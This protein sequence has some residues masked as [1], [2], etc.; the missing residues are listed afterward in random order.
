MQPPA[1]AA[2]LPPSTGHSDR[3]VSPTSPGPIS[4]EVCLSVCLS[5]HRRQLSLEWNVGGWMRLDAPSPT[6][7]QVNE[8]RERERERAR[9]RGGICYTC[10]CPVL[11]YNCK[12][13]HIIKTLNCLL[14]L[15]AV[16]F[17]HYS[18]RTLSCHLLILRINGLNT[19]IRATGD[20][21]DRTYAALYA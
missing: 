12:F 1:S 6:N 21:G 14:K 20:H 4:L 16:T 2:C 9:E 8:E 18:R 10:P 5:L 15:N 7:G 19:K 17:T 3:I 13:K 11:P